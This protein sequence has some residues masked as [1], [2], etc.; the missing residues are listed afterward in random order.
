MEIR[1]GLQKAVTEYAKKNGLDIHFG[2]ASFSAND[3]NFKVNAKISGALSQKESIAEVMIKQ[4][5]LKKSII[6]NGDKLTLVEFSSRSWKRPWVVSKNG[7]LWK[8]SAEFV[9]K[10]FKK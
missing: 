1:E 8:Y 4:K 2:N 3:I 6:Y 10:N 5:N 7:K 9:L